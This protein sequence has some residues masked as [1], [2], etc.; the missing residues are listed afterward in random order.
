MYGLFPWNLHGGLQGCF[1]DGQG[2]W[3][4]FRRNPGILGWLTLLLLLLLAVQ[5]LPT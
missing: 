3:A 1:E 2:K 5:K 4:W